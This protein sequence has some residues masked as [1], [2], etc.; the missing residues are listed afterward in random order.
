MKKITLLICAFICVLS[1]SCTQN[2]ATTYSNAKS[3]ANQRKSINVLKCYGVPVDGGF[4]DVKREFAKKGVEYVDETKDF[5]YKD[6]NISVYE[7]SLSKKVHMIM[8][9][10]RLRG[11]RAKAERIADD[12]YE[13]LLED[14]GLTVAAPFEYNEKKDCKEAYLMLDPNVPTDELQ[15]VH[16]EL[17]PF[18]EDNILWIT[19]ENTKNIG[20]SDKYYY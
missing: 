11:N 9:H 14:K 15:Y 13:E 5:K 2:G 12:Y 16:V 18:F 10:L 19:Y 3:A 17:V 20:K 6:W 4:W 7:D 8:C 1:H